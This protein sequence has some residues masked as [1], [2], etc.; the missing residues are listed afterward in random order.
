MQRLISVTVTGRIEVS[1]YF[2]IIWN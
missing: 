2:V 1:F